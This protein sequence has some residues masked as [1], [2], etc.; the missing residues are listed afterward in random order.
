MTGADKTVDMCLENIIASVVQLRWQ[1]KQ[2]W[3][4]A[5]DNRT[6]LPVRFAEWGVMREKA[7]SWDNT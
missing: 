5:Q 3:L 2:R 7:L 4:A 6:A 1:A